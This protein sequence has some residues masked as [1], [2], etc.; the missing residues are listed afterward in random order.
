[1]RSLERLLTD[2]RSISIAA[3]PGD[4]NVVSPRA[5]VVYH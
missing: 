5:T 4:E 3:S 2:C 1:M